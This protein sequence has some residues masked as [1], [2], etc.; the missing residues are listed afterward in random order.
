MRFCDRPHGTARP[1]PLVPLPSGRPTSLTPEAL[2]KPS[3]R[4]GMPLLPSSPL[5]IPRPRWPSFLPQFLLLPLCLRQFFFGLITS[6]FY[7]FPPLGAPGWGW[8]GAE[9]TDHSSLELRVWYAG[10]AGETSAEQKPEIIRGRREAHLFQEALPDDTHSQPSL[11]SPT[12]NPL[13]LCP[14][15]L[16]WGIVLFPQQGQ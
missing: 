2:H 10:E 8:V 7:V 3:S 15:S 5:S 1:H 13:P 12:L 16:V 11:S 4:P 6:A 14:P 9:T